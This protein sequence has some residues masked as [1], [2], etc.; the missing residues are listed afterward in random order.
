MTLTN[1]RHERFCQLVA[2]GK[3]QSD[4]YRQV[5]PKSKGWKEDAVHVRASE[6]AGKVSVRVG[7]LKEA[8]ANRAVMTKIECCEVLTRI[9]RSPDGDGGGMA[10]RLAAIGILSKLMGYYAPEK[11]EQEVRFAPDEAVATRIGAELARLRDGQ[12]VGLTCLA[13]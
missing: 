4:A 7:E 10:S 8:G 6:L 1:N 5:Y 2:S 12:K 11:I 13:G 3:S 9:I